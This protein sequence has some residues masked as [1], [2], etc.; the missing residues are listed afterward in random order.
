[1][2]GYDLCE[3]NFALRQSRFATTSTVRRAVTTPDSGPVLNVAVSCSLPGDWSC[4]TRTEAE[5]NVP[6]ANPDCVVP[7]TDLPVVTRRI[8]VQL[9]LSS[10][11]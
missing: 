8:C 9:C 3:M 2:R 10:D 7:S 5:Q 11:E 6:Q 1:M 4:G